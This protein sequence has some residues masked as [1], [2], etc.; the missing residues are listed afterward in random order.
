MTNEC[1]IHQLTIRVQ[2]LIPSV[3]SR[4]LCQWYSKK[5]KS[6]SVGLIMISPL[7]DACHFDYRLPWLL[8]SFLLYFPDFTMHPAIFH[9]PLLLLL[10]NKLLGGKRSFSKDALTGKLSTY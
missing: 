10:G 8:I 4:N 3:I 1:S 7:F 9:Q 5:K 2:N 6:L